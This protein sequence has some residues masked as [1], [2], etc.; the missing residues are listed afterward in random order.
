MLAP[1]EPPALKAIRTVT[2]IPDQTLMSSSTPA[3]PGPSS[4]TAWSPLSHTIALSICPTCGRLCEKRGAAWFH[5]ISSTSP[6]GCPTDPALVELVTLHTVA[7]TCPTASVV[8]NPATT[9]SSEIPNMMNGTHLSV[10]CQSIFAST[11][12]YDTFAS[13]ASEDGLFPRSSFSGT[14]SLK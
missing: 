8:S 6:Y 1:E 4:P 2:S 12:D 7:P 11:L 9:I 5:L 3:N 14:G 13:Q 10:S